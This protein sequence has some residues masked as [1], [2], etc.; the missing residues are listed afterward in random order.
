MKTFY[1][2]HNLS[3]LWPKNQHSGKYLSLRN[4]TRRK[5]ETQNENLGINI[6]K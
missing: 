2:K 4:Y 1:N 6:T 3:N 5:R